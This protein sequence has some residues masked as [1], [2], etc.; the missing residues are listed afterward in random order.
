MHEL[1]TIRLA[2]IGC[3]A[4][5][6]HYHLPLLIERQDVEVVH[7]VDRDPARTARLAEHFKHAACSADY[8]SIRDIDA[9]LVAVPHRLHAPVALEL[10]DRGISVLVEKP[11]AMSTAECRAMIAAAHRNE[12]VLAVGMQKRFSRA[13]RLIKQMIASGMLGKILDFDLREG[14]IYGWQSV[15]S[16]MLSKE[17]GGGVVTGVGVHA[18]DLLLWWLGDAASVEYYDDALGGIEANCEYHIR[19]ANGAQGILEFSRTRTL[20]NTWRIRGERGILEFGTD[21]KAELRLTVEGSD[22]VL[23]NERGGG[24]ARET[25]WDQLRGQFDDFV[26][27][28]RHHRSPLV[29]GEEGMRVIALMEAGERSRKTLYQPWVTPPLNA[30]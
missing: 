26:D 2:L 21:W 19:M 16:S 3:G 25:A 9:A 10:L 22:V 23:S 11:M 7:L 5:T 15:D 20:R 17:L 14:D 6:E 8:Q 24:E 13:C 18:L 4:V 28:V 30:V 1:T 27:A 12:A 29:S